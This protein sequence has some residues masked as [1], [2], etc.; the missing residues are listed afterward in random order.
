MSDF[1]T[2]REAAQ[3]LGIPPRRIKQLWTQH[4]ILQVKVDR[5]PMI[6]AECLAQVDGEWVVRESV[7]GTLMMLLDAGFSDEEATDWMLAE[8]PDWGK[9]ALKLLAENRVREVRNAIIP[10]AF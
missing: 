6:P 8:N 10:L 2:V 5:E 3:R 1:L 4:Q 7:R 9:S